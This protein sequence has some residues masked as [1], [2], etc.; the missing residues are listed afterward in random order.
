MDGLYQPPRSSQEAK[1]L[2]LLPFVKKFRVCVESSDTAMF[3]LKRLNW[4]ILRQF[5]ALTNVRELAIDYL[6]VPSF[7]PRI[8]RHFGHFSPTVRSLALR[9]P[10]G[11]SRQI[12]FFIGLFQHLDDLELL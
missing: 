11:T 7:M 9:K 2:G 6:D 3:S 4:G 1:K 8:R 12:I 10:K 5:S